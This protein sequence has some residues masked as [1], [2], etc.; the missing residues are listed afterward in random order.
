[1]FSCSFCVCTDIFLF[2]SARNVFISST[3]ESA[4]VA[5]RPENVFFLPGIPLLI[6]FQNGKKPPA[7]HLVYSL[8]V[9]EVRFPTGIFPWLDCRIS[10]IYHTKNTFLCTV[11]MQVGVEYFSLVT[12][13][14]S[15]HYC[16]WFFNIH[17]FSFIVI[18][19]KMKKIVQFIRFF[20]SF[21]QCSIALFK[22]LLY[23]GL[24]FSHCFQFGNFFQ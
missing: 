22:L 1:M 20:M 11:K 3:F 14:N 9:F 23:S 5:I 4:N 16:S 15:G 13:P 24:S 19:S 7:T 10:S 2:N 18:S 6:R 21:R 8:Q 17:M 12:D